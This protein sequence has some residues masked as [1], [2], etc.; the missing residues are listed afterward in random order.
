MIAGLDLAVDPGM[1]VAVL[2]RNGTGKTLLLQTLAGLRAPTAG[3]LSALS[4]MAID[5]L[6][7]RQVARQRPARR[8]WRTRPDLAGARQRRSGSLCTPPAVGRAA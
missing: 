3:A 8:T 5:S 1:F 7:R 2:G 6:S 4:G